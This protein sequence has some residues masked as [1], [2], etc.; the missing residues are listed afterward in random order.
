MTTTPQ[1]TL[2]VPAK[3][4]AGIAAGIFRRDGGVIRWTD[5]GRIYTFLKDAAPS[6]EASEQVLSRAAS[7]VKSRG[8]LVAVGVVGTVAAGTAAYTYLRR[9]RVGDADV[10]ETVGSL[11][12]SLRTYMD[13][14]R[15]GR[16]D[17]ALISKLIAD[18]DAVTQL[19]DKDH[20]PF[21]FSSELWESMVALIVDH[22]QQLAMAFEVDLSELPRDA[23]PEGN[24]TIIDLRRHLEA[25][26][27]IISGAA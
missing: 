4:A 21:D 24:A 22:T 19:R 2:E 20:E 26:Q 13:A 11:N 6:T 3:I 5:S 23:P 27:R 16:L 17:A 25:Q 18:L 9:R 14:A 15:S 10:P 1:P 7:V 8:T 12:D